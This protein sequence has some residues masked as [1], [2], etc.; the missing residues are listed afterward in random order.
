MRIRVVIV[1]RQIHCSNKPCGARIHLT[2]RH[3]RHGHG[4]RNAVPGQATPHV[5]LRSAACLREGFCE[6]LQ[7]DVD[8]VP[9]FA[10]SVDGVADE[11]DAALCT[12]LG[13]GRTFCDVTPSVV[14]HLFRTLEGTNPNRCSA[15]DS[16]QLLLKARC[17]HSFP[18]SAASVISRD[19]FVTLGQTGWS[20]A[21]HSSPGA[22]G[23]VSLQQSSTA[24]SLEMIALCRT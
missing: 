3:A 11:S 22:A 19:H 10:E 15:S 14:Q 18:S 17:V 6:V 23:R 4:T 1:I 16:Q 5:F 12:Q 13:A 21:L 7:G 2:V 8:A 9:A 20:W 24:S